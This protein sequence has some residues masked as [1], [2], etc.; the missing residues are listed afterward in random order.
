MVG[1]DDVLAGLRAL[2]E[3]DRSV[4]SLK[5]WLDANNV[6]PDFASFG[7]RSFD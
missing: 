6:E 7:T 1:T 5:A 3:R 4:H 2:F